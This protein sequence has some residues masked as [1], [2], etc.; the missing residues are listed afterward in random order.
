MSHVAQMQIDDV[1]AY[2]HDLGRRA[3]DASRALAAAHTAAK[4]AA[5]DAIADDLDR[6]RDELM[7]ENRKD[8]EA[9]AAKGLDAAL[10]DR[11]EL[12]PARVDAMI[13]G[14]HETFE[15]RASAEPAE[16]LLKLE[17]RR[18]LRTVSA[19]R[20]RENVML[21]SWPVAG[22]VATMLIG[23]ASNR[24]SARSQ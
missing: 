16:L 22:C 18:I 15:L 23:P 11:L 7:A 3:R 8:L 10:L 2:M 20:P 19:K 14:L 5:L 4:D 12:T 1:S 9:G 17:D 6:V 24:S 13:E 21:S